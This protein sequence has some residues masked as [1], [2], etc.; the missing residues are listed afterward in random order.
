MQENTIYIRR[1]VTSIGNQAF[2]AY[3]SNGIFTTWYGDRKIIHVN[4][5]NPETTYPQGAIGMG[6]DSSIAQINFGYVEE[7]EE[8][9]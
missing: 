8:I 7:T 3:G 1:S 2:G 5:E 9:A 6:L 4:I